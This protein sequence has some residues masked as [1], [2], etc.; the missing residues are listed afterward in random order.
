[1][2]KRILLLKKQMLANLQHTPTVKQM[3]QSVNLSEPHLQQLFKRE[4]G[5]SPIQYLRNERLGKARKLLEESFMRVK[6]IGFTVG[7]SD[8]S[9]FVRDF[10]QEFG[11][12]PSKYRKQH[13]VNTEDEESDINKS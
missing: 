3:A 4:V 11:A 8:Q 10:K 7:M 2:D 6:E 13:W 12:S 1:M 9:R 5:T